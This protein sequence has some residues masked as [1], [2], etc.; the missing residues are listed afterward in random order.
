MIA[1]VL[2]ANTLASGAIAGSGTLAAIIDAW[3]A[4]L[5]EVFVS[6]VLLEE[7]SRTLRKPYF[8][9]RLTAELA[10]R[11]DALLRRQ[12]RFTT[13]TA[14]VLGVATRP[15]D[16]Q[17]LATAVSAEA[18]YL[19]TGDA[20]LQKLVGTCTDAADASARHVQ[21]DASLRATGR[22]RRR[23]GDSCRRDRRNKACGAWTRARRSVRDG[24]S[25]SPGT[26]RARNRTPRP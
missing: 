16:D 12:A 4:N 17:V 2:D 22:R 26:S 9:Q 11:F 6:D 5:F 23:A 24:R 14:H 10:E 21:A 8:R 25:P 7:V 1:V 13:V 15:E 20:Q 3:E 19:V 18:R